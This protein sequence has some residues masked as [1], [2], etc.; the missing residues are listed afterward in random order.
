MKYLGNTSTIKQPID[1]GLFSRRPRPL[2]AACGAWRDAHGRWHREVIARKDLAQP[3][4]MEDRQPTN[5]SVSSS[6]RDAMSK[7]LRCAPEIQQ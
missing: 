7:D 4:A 2:L 1:P 5:L 3:R 6:G